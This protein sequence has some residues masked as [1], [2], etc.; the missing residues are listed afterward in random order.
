M[1]GPIVFCLVLG[2][3]LLLVSCCCAS[4]CSIRMYPIPSLSLCTRL[5]ICFLQAGK[6]HFGYIYGFGAFGCVGIHTIVNLMASPS[7]SL[8][9]S[10]VFSV[11]GYGLL[12]IVSL[13]ALAVF[14]DLRSIFGAALG[15]AC[16]FFCTYSGTRF[17]VAAAQM[18]AQRWLIAYPTF[19]F[20]ACFALMTIF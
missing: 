19:L 4:A 5:L 1:A 10:R 7:H 16:I 18:D 8:D 20:Y 14:V 17:F 12:P 15:V 11:L 9:V 13:A 3:C 6:V 2:F